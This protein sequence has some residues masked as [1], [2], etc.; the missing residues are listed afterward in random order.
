MTNVEIWFDVLNE[1]FRTLGRQTIDF[2]PNFLAALVVFLVG[3]IIAV[4]IGHLVRR[5]VDLLRVD[6]AVERLQITSAFQRAGVPLNVS[7]LLGWLVKWFLIIVFL[8]TSADILGLEAIKGFLKDVVLYIPNVIIAVVVLLIGI[9]VA[10][11]V[12]DVIERAVAAAKLRSADFLA[13]LAKWS[14]LVFSFLI[15]LVH[16]KV[17]QELI[18]TLFTGFV[19]MLALAGGLAFGLGGKDQAEKFIERLRKDLSS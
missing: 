4:G 19:A 12:H 17:A 2:L 11:F 1:T 5:I 6:I 10:N 3:L 9:V 13:G 18:I 7:A 15:A 14:I 16:L 8:I